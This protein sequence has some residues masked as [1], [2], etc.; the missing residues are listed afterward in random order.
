MKF[1]HFTSLARMQHDH[2]KLQEGEVLAVSKQSKAEL[3]TWMPRLNTMAAQEAQLKQRQRTMSGRRKTVDH[4]QPSGNRVTVARGSSLLTKLGSSSKGMPSNALIQFQQKQLDLR[5]VFRLGALATGNGPDA[6]KAK[7][8]WGEIWSDPSCKT[9]TNFAGDELEPLLRSTPRKLGPSAGTNAPVR[10]V[11]ARYLIAL[12]DRGERLVRR[13]DIPDDAFIDLP[14][15]RR[16][17]EGYARSLRILA[18]SYPW[19]TSQHPDPRGD[20]LKLLAAVLRRFLTDVGGTYAVFLDFISLYQRDATGFRTEEESRMMKVALSQLSDIY[21][22]QYAYVLKI[23]KQP[24]DYPDG[25]G[26]ENAAGSNIAP[27][28]QR[29]WCFTEAS[30]ACLVKSARLILDLANFDESLFGD[31]DIEQVVHHCNV[32]RAPPTTPQDFHAMVKMLRFTNAKA[33]IDIVSAMYT[34]AFETKLAHAEMLEF[35]N[36]HWGDAEA[37]GLAK[38]LVA[39]HN[40]REIHL[41]RNFIMNAGLEA[42]AAVIKQPD[43]MPRLLHVYLDT[44]PHNA[45]GKEAIAEALRVKKQLLIEAEKKR[46]QQRDRPNPKKSECTADQTDAAIR[47][48]ACQRGRSCRKHMSM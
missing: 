25:V 31:A 17:P 9:W 47:L 16:M 10:L 21:A 27:Y 11:D 1:V 14:E 19:L 8:F 40:V 18:V 43:T 48:Q 44:T 3:T 13:Q 6:A 7:G 38:A 24:A 33:D 29:G 32:G 46:V 39:A 36:L 2:R 5:N 41:Q 34:R 37:S 20:H 35:Q 30:M 28:A 12:D 26:F 42:I 45:N 23:T 15:L 4:R 22:H